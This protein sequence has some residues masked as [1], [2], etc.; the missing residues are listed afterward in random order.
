VEGSGGP[1]GGEFSEPVEALKDPIGE[2]S[3][4][5]PAL[6]EV[7]RFWRQL[8]WLAPPLILGALLVARPRIPHAESWAVL[9]AGVVLALV[10]P[11]VNLMSGRETAVRVEQIPSRRQTAALLVDAVV[12]LTLVAVFSLADPH[13]DTFALLL[14]PQLQMATTRRMPLMTVTAAVGCVA[15]VG[16]ELYAAR[17]HGLAVPWSAITGRLALLLLGAVILGRIALLLARHLRALQELHRDAAHRAL[18]DPLTGLP[19]RALLFERIGV[20][21]ARQERSGARFAV[22]FVDLDDLKTVN[23]TLGHAAGDELLR[24]IATRLGDEL[25]A[26]DTPARVGGDEFAALLDDPGDDDDLENLARRLLDRLGR[27]ISANSLDLPASVSIGVAT[28]ERIS[29]ADELIRRA[30]AA[31]YRAKAEG[32]GRVAHFDV[33]DPADIPRNGH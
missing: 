7:Q 13:S 25:R 19:N 24:V 1:R 33:D 26:T 12:I 18:H 2:L 4:T 8:R 17:L 11:V 31:M 16:I 30:D 28:S 20:A 5:L 32:K 10:P 15:F 29:S 23:D 3:G 21:L 9:A 22:V 6:T 27:P 14:L